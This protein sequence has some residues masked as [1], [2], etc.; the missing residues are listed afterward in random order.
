VCGAKYE[1]GMT[2]HEV[3][4]YS[5]EFRVATLVGFQLICRDCN[6]VNHLGKA[7]D[8]GLADQAVKH[9]MSV[10]GLSKEQALEIVSRAVDTWLRRSSISDWTIEIRSDLVENYPVLNK[11]KLR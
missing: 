8:L 2:C 10:N 4:E 3:W 9:L 11:V 6:F 7:K 5:E 1:K